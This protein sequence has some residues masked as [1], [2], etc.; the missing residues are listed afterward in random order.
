MQTFAPEGFWAVFRTH[1]SHGSGSSTCTRKV[2]DGSFP[3]AGAFLATEPPAALAR[4][5]EG[6]R[7][8]RRETELGKEINRAP[9]IEPRTVLSFL[10]GFH[11]RMRSLLGDLEG[12]LW[13]SAGIVLSS[14][15][16]LCHELV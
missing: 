10:K 2:K 8:H 3:S 13:G 14:Y 6:G 12:G 1:A 9:C 7:H 4:V 15:R 5:D 16:G 11:H